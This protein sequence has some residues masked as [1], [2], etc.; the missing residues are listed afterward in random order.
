MLAAGHPESRYIA[1]VC[2]A[3]A[4]DLMNKI[5]RALELGGRTRDRLT[6]LGLVFGAG[7]PVGGDLPGSHRVVDQLTV[8]LVFWI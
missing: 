8:T 6:R 1:A 3:Y 5:R 2:A 4:V 7:S